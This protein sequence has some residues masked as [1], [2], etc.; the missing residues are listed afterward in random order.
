[1]KT[2]KIIPVLVLLLLL[3][4]VMLSG[5]F[6]DLA[7]D[8]PEGTAYR[9]RLL[10]GDVADDFIEHKAN[11]NESDFFNV[12]MDLLEDRVLPING[13]LYTDFPSE[14]KSLSMDLLPGH[15]RVLVSFINYPDEGI[16]WVKLSDPFTV[17]SDGKSRLDIS[18]LSKKLTTFDQ[19][20]VY[21]IDMFPH[22]SAYFYGG[23]GQEVAMRVR[24][25]PK[26]AVMD[27]TTHRIVDSKGEICPPVLY[28]YGQ[29][30][31]EFWSWE[32]GSG[33]SSWFF[34]DYVPVHTYSI[35]VEFIPIGEPDPDPCTLE[36]FLPS[37]L[38]N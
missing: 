18:Q 6:S 24:L 9:V 33:N 2:F 32:Q 10:P 29:S 25:Y 37:F 27:K 5:C 23:I 16:Y 36:Y 14:Y 38:E 31:E 30:S 15:Y 12:K 8:V 19:L 28:N 34:L 1:M 26:D 21:I 4:S 35:L 3:L 11:Y 22:D 17:G 20:G 13:K 7:P